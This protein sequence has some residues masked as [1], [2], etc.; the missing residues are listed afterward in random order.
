MPEPL[1]SD[2]NAALFGVAGR[3]ERVF[4]GL[5][6]AAL[7]LGVGIVVPAVAGP[8]NRDLPD[9]ISPRTAQ[10]IAG[11]IGLVFV[12]IGWLIAGVVDD[13]RL[14]LAAKTYSRRHG[15]WPFVRRRAGGFLDF[16]HLTLESEERECHDREVNVWVVQLAWKNPPQERMQLFDQVNWS[17]HDAE[18]NL[19]RMR[20]R[21]EKLARQLDLP[22]QEA[23][24]ECPTAPPAPANFLDRVRRRLY[25]DA[26]LRMRER[27]KAA[28]VLGLMA[29][30]SVL[31][32]VRRADLRLGDF[33]P[34]YAYALWAV[35]V[36]Y[37]AGGVLWENLA[38]S[39]ADLI[40]TPRRQR[41]VTA[42]TL[43]AAAIC[44][45]APVYLQ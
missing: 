44:L 34:F 24:F 1:H 42:L 23:P 27:K 11:V 2:E 15:I 39:R 16:S 33:V 12:L 17:M 7:G 35:L 8:E 10:F 6:F 3:R 38:P 29:V 18:H 26:D 13:L 14:D 20:T 21:L 5:A 9:A 43:A 37:V 30:G 40:Q 32:E 41:L 25:G 45:I 19:A 36:L 28:V 22:I 4:W 31:V